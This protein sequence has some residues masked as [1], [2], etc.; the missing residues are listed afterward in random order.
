MSV[1]APQPPPVETWQTQ[2]LRMIV[3]TTESQVRTDREWWEE[4]IG[5]T[6]DAST[7]K[8][9]E[10]EDGG[11]HDGVQLVLTIDPIRMQ[12]TASAQMDVEQFLGNMPL[13]GPYMDRKL[14]FQD[15]MTRWLRE[16][17]PPIKR[18]AFLATLVQKVESRE[19]G[20][21]KLNQYLRHLELFTDSSDF[22]YQIN[23][24]RQSELGITGLEINRLSTWSVT[25]VQRKVG[26]LV[27]SEDR[28]ESAEPQLYCSVGLDV[29]TI[30][31][32]PCPTLSAD[33]LPE[34]FEELINMATE[35]A[36]DGD[37]RVVT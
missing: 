3:F 20:Y 9:I 32:Y 24:K 28:I 7:R 27:G 37:V 19:E 21:V 31:E 29:N 17:C 2:S 8:K 25:I 23:R 35:I 13:L 5:S 14:W 12:W 33:R 15:L 26:T 36:R 34:I 6:P 18:L 1:N 30:H 10:R 11:L 16:R 4:L 22:L